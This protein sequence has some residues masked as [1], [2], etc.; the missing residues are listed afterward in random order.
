MHVK[1]QCSWYF[2]KCLC[3]SLALIMG[4]WELQSKSS[5]S[6][7]QNSS[8]ERTVI[9]EFMALPKRDMMQ[10]SIKYDWSNF[11]CKMVDGLE[12]SG[13]RFRK[14]CCPLITSQKPTNIKPRKKKQLR[15]VSEKIHTDAWQKKRGADDASHWNKDTE[16]DD[17][18]IQMTRNKVKVTAITE[19][20]RE[21]PTKKVLTMSVP[22]CR[23]RP[24]KK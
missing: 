7:E 2:S 17:R 3:T 24:K 16:M 23:G 20:M 4:L 12:L 14:L 22:G 21:P 6:A 10:R 1:K 5:S 18:H 13:R 11:Y 15:W 8:F 9:T 19:N